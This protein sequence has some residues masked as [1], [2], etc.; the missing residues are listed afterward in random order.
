MLI[1]FGTQMSFGVFFKPMLNEFGWTRAATAGS[2]SVMMVVGGVMGIFSGKL[3][4]RFGPRLVISITGIFL[5]AGFLLM[6]RIDSLWQLYLFYGV[7]V[8]IGSSGIFIPLTSMIIR[9]FDRRRGLMSGIA[10]AGIGLGI[11]TVPPISSQIIENYNW[12]TAFLVTGAVALVSMVAL[13]QF[14]KDKPASAK[15]PKGNGN[16][17][18]MTVVPAKQFSL[19]EALHTRQFWLLFAAWFF[20]GLN[21]QVVMVHIVPYATDLGWTAI[22][23]ATII[24]TIGLV[25]TV[26]R[27]FIGLTGDRFGYKSTIITSFVM[28]AIAFLG[29]TF[30]DSTW[31]LYSFAVLFG[32]GSGFGVLLTP[33]VAELFGMKAL[34]AILGP[35]I[36]GSSL[37]SAVGPVLAGHIFDTTGSYFPAFLLTF[38]LV[39]IGGVS[40]LLLKP[41]K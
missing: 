23:A 14:L 37:G 7:L 41:I 15:L 17:E 13:A 35:I 16:A 22:T 12:R 6:S 9:W 3:S 25:S 33:M 28:L 20:Y 11:A 21:Y 32:I 26:A 38:V 18:L 30:I 10:L 8:A 5:G 19:Q 31:M 39:I 2:F 34:G 24:T 29:L 1:G 4:D 27:V 40:I 36:L